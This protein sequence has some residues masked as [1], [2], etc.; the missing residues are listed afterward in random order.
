MSELET[1]MLEPTPWR[2]FSVL[3]STIVVVTA[4]VLL[5]RWTATQIGPVAVGLSLLASV[6]CILLVAS[7]GEWFIHRYAM[8]RGRRFPLFRLATELHHRA[9]H[10]QH[11]TPD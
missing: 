4:F 10:Y 5:G 1:K 11:F 9:H 3:L 8:H 6:V 7:I 2:T